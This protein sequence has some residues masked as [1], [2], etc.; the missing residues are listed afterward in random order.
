VD[1]G[2]R[3]SHSS[4]SQ[5][6][7]SCPP[8]A[9]E[10]NSNGRP[11]FEATI[12]DST[13]RDPRCPSLSSYIHSAPCRR[14]YLS[15]AFVLSV[16]I[17]RNNH[18]NHHNNLQSQQ[19]HQS[20]LI[21]LSISDFNHCRLH[22]SSRLTSLN[23]TTSPTNQPTNQHLHIHHVCLPTASRQAAASASTKRDEHQQ[24]RFHLVHS[25]IHLGPW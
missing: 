2:R 5:A 17:S 6:Q 25:Y 3:L 8:P 23:H 14:L 4:Q 13:E 24:R 11:D 19:Q 16:H 20:T 1:F 7:A 10:P 22:Q 15:L 9:P 21:Y 18:H 12:E